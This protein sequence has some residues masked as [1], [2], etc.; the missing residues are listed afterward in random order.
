MEKQLGVLEYTGSF[1]QDNW[2]LSVSIRQPSYMSSK[3]VY[4]SG[5]GCKLLLKFKDGD[6][7]KVLAKLDATIS[8]V[9]ST[10]SKF[11]PETEQ[12]LVMYNMPAILFPYLRGAITAYLGNAG[13][14]SIILPLINMQ[15]VAKRSFKDAK[16]LGISEE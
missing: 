16:P 2:D 14:G 10:E 1:N 6:E 11:P 7:E 9:F 13:F 3:K 5:V 8:G 4:I 12:S 15:E